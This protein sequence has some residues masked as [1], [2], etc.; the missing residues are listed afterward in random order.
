MN[1]RNRKTAVAVITSAFLVG[2][3]SLAWA[4][5]V[6]PFISLRSLTG[7]GG[8]SVA[9]TGASF[10]PDTPVQIRWNSSEGPVV[11]AA[12][13]PAFSVD[14]AP[15]AGTA[16]GFYYIVAV[17]ENTKSGQAA[18]GPTKAAEVF[19]LTT[20]VAGTRSISDG[21][22]AA[23]N[24]DLWKGFAS[25]GNGLQDAG[26]ASSHSTRASAPLALGLGLVSLSAVTVIAGV[27]FV[28]RRPVSAPADSSKPGRRG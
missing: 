26:L 4:C 2:L 27:W 25:G 21:G 8:T 24:A 17:Q 28:R 12:Q 1:R 6:N 23:A 13:G 15:P 16:A 11:G 19:H 14:V 7:P 9:V 22:P 18:T 5:T 20:A 10:T 3:A